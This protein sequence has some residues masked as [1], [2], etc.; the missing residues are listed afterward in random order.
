M[1]DPSSVP[2]IKGAELLTMLIQHKAAVDKL[3]AEYLSVIRLLLQN[4][5]EM[6][7][8][9]EENNNENSNLPVQDIAA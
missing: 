7:N 4:A 9:K 5:K 3:S 1:I 8:A 6:E 2:S